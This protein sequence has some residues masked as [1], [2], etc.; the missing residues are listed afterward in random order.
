MASAS[1][2]DIISSNPTKEVLGT[3]CRLFES[4]RADLGVAKSS[5]AVQV[6]FS[7][8]AVSMA[9]LLVVTILANVL[10]FSI[11]VSGTASSIVENRER[12]LVCGREGY[13]II[14]LQPMGLLRKVYRTP[15][16]GNS[17]PLQ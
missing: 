3:F 7:T 6:V 2:V 15:H 8:A 10:S 9:L 11:I 5:D 13:S 17:S 14:C 16:G 1:E 4:T 12:L